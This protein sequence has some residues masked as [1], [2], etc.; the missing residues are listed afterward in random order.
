MEEDYTNNID[1]DE[2]DDMPYELDRYNH[3]ASVL[4]SMFCRF[5]KI[6][7]SELDHFM[8]SEGINSEKF[9]SYANSLAWKYRND[10]SDEVTIS[11]IKKWNTA[12]IYMKIFGLLIVIFVFIE[13]YYLN[14]LSS[15]SFP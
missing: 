15:G 6:P 8:G 5:M 13:I 7:E 12:G 3:G 14:S 11:N 10:Y 4:P 9:A 1:I 2:I